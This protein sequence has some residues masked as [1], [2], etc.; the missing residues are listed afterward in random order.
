VWVIDA[1]TGAFK[2]MWGAFGKTPLDPPQLA[3]GAPDPTRGIVD[4]PGPDQYGIVHG[5]KVSNDGQVYVADRGN[6]RIQV[7]SLDGTYRT[8][9]FV[10][11]GTSNASCGTVA[12]SPD[13]DQQYIYCPD[14]NKG[15]IV[16]VDRK[17]LATVTAFSSRGA[18]PGQLQNPHTVAV[19]S[20]GNLY[21]AEVAPGRR[22]QKFAITR[23]AAPK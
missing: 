5:A 23:T 1:E 3:A 10:N 2:R 17:T 15:E 6:R 7:F 16:I 22:L 20:K 19:D 8:Q 14:F 12:F 21:T 18:A 4:G 9:G 11:R 13:R